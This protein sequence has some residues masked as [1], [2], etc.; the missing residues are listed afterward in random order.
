M[1][2]ERKSEKPQ[3]VC[4]AEK[5]L[6]A[7]TAWTCLFGIYQSWIGIPEIEGMMNGPLQGLVPIEPHKLLEWIIAGYA[8]L[9]IASA[10]IVLKIG[11]GKNWAKSSVLWG[12]ILQAI[13]IVWPPYHLGLDFLADVP[14][15]G[16][17]IY[18]LYLLYTKPGSDW[19]LARNPTI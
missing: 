2:D 17:Q 14:D 1:A 8:G 18:A 13:C 4:R 7:W 9:A 19:F 5:A 10:W 11:A 16:L 6:W 15:I 12:F 3:N